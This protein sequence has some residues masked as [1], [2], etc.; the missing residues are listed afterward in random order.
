MTNKIIFN[1]IAE[2][3]TDGKLDKIAGGLPGIAVPGL[4]GVPFVTIPSDI[5][6]DEPKDGGAT[7]SW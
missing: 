2:R 7:G 3:L 5:D 1:I 4:P 6:K